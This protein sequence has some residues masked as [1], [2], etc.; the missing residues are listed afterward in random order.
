MVEIHVCGLQ[1]S[2]LTINQIFIYQYIRISV[3]EAS[4]R[5]GVLCAKP[6]QLRWIDGWMDGW[7]DGRKE[8]KIDG[9]VNGQ[10]GG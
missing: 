2:S 3:L 10:M 1:K 4:L 7:M 5:D 9:W 8:G 6:E